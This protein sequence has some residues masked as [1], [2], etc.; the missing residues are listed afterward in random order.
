[1]ERRDYVSSLQ[2]DMTP[3]PI[4]TVHFANNNTGDGRFNLELIQAG[5]KNTFT[6]IK[7]LRTD[8]RKNDLFKAG[9]TF[10]MSKY[11][12]FFENGLMDYGDDFGYSIK[13]VSITGTGENAKAVIRITRQ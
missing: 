1:M 10:T 4:G 9:D 5:S 6:D 8:L 3:C 12:Q 7:N 2:P 13:V 11:S